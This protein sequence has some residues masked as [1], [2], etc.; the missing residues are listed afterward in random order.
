MAAL[1]PITLRAARIADAAALSHLAV[2]SFCAKFGGLYT[3][4]DL[5]TFLDSALSEA[6]ITAELA[7]PDRL[8]C[9][10]ELDGALI[11]YAALGLA[12]GF[13]DHSRGQRTIELKKLYTDPA[14][15]GGGIGST[16]LDWAL[17]E[18]RAHGFDEMQLSVW[19]GNEDAQRFY[20]RYGFA[21][22]ADVTFRVGEQIDHEFLFSIML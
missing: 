12:C 16:L 1:P 2:T 22:V 6:A 11:G 5:A 8:Y 19:S 21:H 13:P 10:A 3:P 14:R 7:N 9:L 18:A 4:D 15:T 17:G 20:A